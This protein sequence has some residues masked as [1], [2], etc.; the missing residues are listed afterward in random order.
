MTWQ[1]VQNIL[2]II[3]GF[4]RSLP[5]RGAH[6]WFDQWIIRIERLMQSITGWR[7]V[8]NVISIAHLLQIDYSKS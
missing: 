5:Y 3:S 1:F 8:W 4:K 6:V 7:T 2:E